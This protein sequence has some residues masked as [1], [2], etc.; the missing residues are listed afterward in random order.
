MLKS[1]FVHY[2][3]QQLEDNVIYIS[4]AFSMA[5][6]KCACGCGK[7]VVMEL[8]WGDV[9]WKNGWSITIEDSLISFS[10]SILNRFACKSHYYITKSEVVWC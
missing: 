1:E 10:P 3:P 9:A 2:I 7:K 6:H 5:I 8:S 4:E